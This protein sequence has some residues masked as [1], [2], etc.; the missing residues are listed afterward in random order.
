MN[1]QNHPTEPK[2][3]RTTGANILYDFISDFRYNFLS[4]LKKE[5]EEKEKLGF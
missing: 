3:S 1:V 4:L 5:L 2:S